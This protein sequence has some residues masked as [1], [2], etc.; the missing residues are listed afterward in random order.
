MGEDSLFPLKEQVIYK[1]TT[2]NKF[3]DSN[4]KMESITRAGNNKFLYFSA[5]VG[6]L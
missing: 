4:T 5:L 6:E 2:R 3:E 1:M